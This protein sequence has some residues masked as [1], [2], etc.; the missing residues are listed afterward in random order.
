MKILL[1]SHGSLASG[2]KS[3]LEVL[4]GIQPQITAID[5]Y[6]E[7]GEPDEQINRFFD[8]NPIEEIYIL[9]D[10]AY[11]SVSQKV[12][13]Y[14]NEHRHLIAG[15]NLPLALQL[16]TMPTFN[17]QEVLKDSKDSIVYVNELIKQT[18]LD[19]DDE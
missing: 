1:V 15:M 7:F 19:D 9:A 6:G 5:A 3:S 18:S 17:L 10:L 12:M 8:D 13:P 4:A 2:M 11:G 16:V 14:L